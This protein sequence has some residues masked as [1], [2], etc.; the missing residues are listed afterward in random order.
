MIF[1]QGK[2]WSIIVDDV[3]PCIPWK[4]TKLSHDFL[5]LDFKNL[6]PVF[7]KVELMD[8]DGALFF[9]F[10][11]SARRKCQTW[12]SPTRF[13]IISWMECLRFNSFYLRMM[14][15]H[16]ILCNRIPCWQLPMRPQGDGS[17]AA[18]ALADHLRVAAAGDESIFH[19]FE[20]CRLK[21]R[22]SPSSVPR[23][24]PARLTPLL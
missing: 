4:C 15:Q 6:D 20:P 1:V 18:L 5:H 10:R 19:G 16:N 8:L 22:T 2:L 7:H 23:F 17:P 14:H 12:V 21:I 24:H 9:P 3:C 13:I 11:N